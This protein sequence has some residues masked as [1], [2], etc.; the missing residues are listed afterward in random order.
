MSQVWQRGS[1]LSDIFVFI[2][3]LELCGFDGRGGLVLGS[4]IRIFG[5]SIDMLQ[6]YLTKY[7]EALL[8]LSFSPR[9]VEYG[10]VSGRV[11][12]AVSCC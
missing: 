3:L 12:R 4:D 10:Y 1:A 6:S 5:Q 7:L 11:T 2:E 9:D 8:L